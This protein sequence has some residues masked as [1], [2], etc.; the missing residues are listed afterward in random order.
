MGAEP[1]KKNPPGRGKKPPGATKDQRRRAYSA[2]RRRAGRW[3]GGRGKIPP[4]GGKT[5]GR[6]WV[7]GWPAPLVP[8][9][10]VFFLMSPRDG[11]V[12]LGRGRARGLG[13]GRSDGGSRGSPSSKALGKVR[14]EEG[15]RGPGGGRMGWHCIFPVT[16]LPERR[17]SPM[18]SDF[19]FIKEGFY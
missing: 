14:G 5:P 4:E 6:G 10:R 2:G 18:A 13:R 16:S 1:R 7:G 15:P 11:G 9:T 8:E 17:K 3:G 12:P 19:S